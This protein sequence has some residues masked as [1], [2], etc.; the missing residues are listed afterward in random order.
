MKADDPALRHEDEAVVSKELPRLATAILAAD[1]RE[2]AA[3]V[4]R[5]RVS[6]GF[7]PLHGGAIKPRDDGLRMFRV[8]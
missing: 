5:R 7:R 8:C 6:F 4:P 2:A 3:R 1:E